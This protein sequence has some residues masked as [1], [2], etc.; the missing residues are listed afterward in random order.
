MSQP[1]VGGAMHDE[2]DI[3]RLEDALAGRRP[4]AQRTA[5]PR[6]VAARHGRSG[7]RP[8][9]AAFAWLPV[10]APAPRGAEAPPAPWRPL[11]TPAAPPRPHPE[12]APAT[13]EIAPPPERP[14]QPPRSR[15]RRAWLTTVALATVGGV[16]LGT[17]LLA[18]N[19]A[20]GAAGTR[21]LTVVV[22]D[23]MTVE[24][25]ECA[26]ADYE[27]TVFDGAALVV[28]DDGG[29]EL[30]SARLDSPPATTDRGCVWAT[31]FDGLPD[32]PAY[33]LRVT[34]GRQ[35]YEYTY[36]QERLADLSWSV[37]VSVVG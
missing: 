17:W 19:A 8:A 30:A 20:L 35:G 3:S 2:Y 6:H 1:D 12:P 13:A 25:D 22:S 16:G 34:A 24:G 26:A 27:G 36:D 28:T 18:E 37:W 29:T 31:T 9:A 10:E 11:G 32:A 4:A 23:A 7:R 33:T 5:V 15:R 14:G 21:S